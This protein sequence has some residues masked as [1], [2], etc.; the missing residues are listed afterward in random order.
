MQLSVIVL[1]TTNP[2]AQNTQSL[3]LVLPVPTCIKPSALIRR[4]LRSGTQSVHRL[5]PMP[6]AKVPVAQAMHS[7]CC[8]VAA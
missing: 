3:A 1:H 8:R 5:L 6:V 7:V 2:G 4:V